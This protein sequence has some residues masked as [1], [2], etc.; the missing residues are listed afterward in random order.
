MKF[1]AAL[2]SVKNAFLVGLLVSYCYGTKITTSSSNRDTSAR[3][4]AAGA[5]MAFFMEFLNDFDTAFPQY[6]SYMMQNRLT[7]PQAVADYYYHMAAL[8]STADLQ[9]DIAQSFPFTQFQTFITAFPWYTSLLNKASVT[10]IYLP[11]HFI[12]DDTQPT[13]TNSSYASQTSSNSRSIVSSTVNANQSITSSVNEENN[14]ADFS[15]TSNSSSLSTTTQS[16]NGACAISLYF[17][18]A[19]FGILAAAL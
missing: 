16:R 15:S 4:A 12:T 13:M 17:P 19:L 11:Q 7:L 6:T 1:A 8:G 10:T 5:D 18:M 3:S 2:Y 9:S 14:T